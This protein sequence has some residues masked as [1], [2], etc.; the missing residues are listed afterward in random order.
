MKVEDFAGVK[1]VFWI[2]GLFQSFQKFD[3][4]GV[5]VHGKEGFSE[6]TNSMLRGDF[7]SE[8]DGLF[9]KISLGSIDQSFPFL[10]EKFAF[11][12]EDMDIPI[13]CMT[14]GHRLDPVPL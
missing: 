7:S 8:L 11:K 9:V 13:S 1:Y 5:K 10:V 3:L 2:E 14:E 4:A 6:K 12:E